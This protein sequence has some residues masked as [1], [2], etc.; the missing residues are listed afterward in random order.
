MSNKNKKLAGEGFD[1]SAYGAFETK[2]DACVGCGACEGVCP[3]KLEIR[4]LLQD[5]HKTLI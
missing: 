1:E 2:A 5:A 4:Q 3:Q